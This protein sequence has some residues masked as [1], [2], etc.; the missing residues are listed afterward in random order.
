MEVTLTESNF[1]SEALES[2]LPVL[3]D[4][5]AQWCGPCKSMLPVVARIAEE[6]SGSLKVGKVN[7]DEQ[8]SLAQDYGVMSIPTFI[9]F[10][11]GKAVARAVGGMPMEDLLSALKIG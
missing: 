8:P 2:A 6:K 9:L 3:V 4:F 11:D 1:K 7:V 5:W 10:K